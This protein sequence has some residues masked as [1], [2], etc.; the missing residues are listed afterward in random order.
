[1][2]EYKQIKRAKIYKKLIQILERHEKF[3]NCYFWSSPSNSSARRAY[4]ERYSSTPINFKLNGVE[5][6]IEQEVN[7]SCKNVYYSFS[8]F[9][10]GEKKDIRTL[11]KI[12]K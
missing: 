2:K 11:K 8:I 3:K 5:Y 7:C 12:V 9:E 10:D 6:C 1:M 4:E